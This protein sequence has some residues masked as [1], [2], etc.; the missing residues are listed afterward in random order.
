[1]YFNLTLF[2]FK[3]QPLIATL[4]NSRD[5]KKA[6]TCPNISAF[7]KTLWSPKHTC[8]HSN[9][10]DTEWFFVE[11][12]WQHAEWAVWWIQTAS[13]CLNKRAQ[14]RIS[15]CH[16]LPLPCYCRS[17]TAKHVLHGWSFFSDASW[18]TVCHYGDIIGCVICQMVLWILVYCLWLTTK[19]QDCKILSFQ[20]H[21][22]YFHHHVWSRLT[23]LLLLLFPQL[24]AEQI[25]GV[26]KN[27]T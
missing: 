18:Y 16:T 23:V 14:W 17:R 3:L 27:K 8:L 4:K 26:N 6:P 2:T 10:T 1:M 12:V 19:F 9:T 11:P 15:S 7:V 21:T 20:E 5:G 24:F 25:Y 22:F 13:V